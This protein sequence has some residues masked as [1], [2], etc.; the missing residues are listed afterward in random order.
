MTPEPEEDGAAVDRY[1]WWVSFLGYVGVVVVYDGAILSRLWNW[2]V[3]TVFDVPMMSMRTGM[4]LAAF[5]FLLVRPL[6]D[7]EYSIVGNLL[8]GTL[9]LV[10]GYAVR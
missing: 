1:T 6:H 2:H 8:L 9:C 5:L 4:G 7:E 3:R 10:L